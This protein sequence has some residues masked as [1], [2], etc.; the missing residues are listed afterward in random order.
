MMTPKKLIA[1]G[2]GLQR[3]QNRIV[4]GYKWKSEAFIE[5]E[6]KKEVRG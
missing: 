5:E 1:L 3:L 6:V 2:A 4:L